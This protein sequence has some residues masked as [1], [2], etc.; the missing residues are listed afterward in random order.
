MCE[1]GNQTEQCPLT[2]IVV[3][4]G[5]SLGCR[6]GEGV[7]T[8]EKVLQLNYI[9]RGEETGADRQMAVDKC[10]GTGTGWGGS[11]RGG[12]TV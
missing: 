8:G 7:V 11:W 12:F 6:G 2:K 10:W 9:V 5:R 4:E 1:Q 3:C